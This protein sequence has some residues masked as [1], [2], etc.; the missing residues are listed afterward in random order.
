MLEE[1]KTIDVEELKVLQMDVLDAVAAF[2]AERGIP[3]SLACGTMLG[4]VRHRGYIPW[5]DDIDIYLLRADYDRL[6]REFPQERSHV[7]L[8]ALERTPHWDKPYAK[9][10]DDRTF[11]VERNN[12]RMRIGVNIDLFPLDAVPDDTS[13]WLRYNRRRRFWQ[14]LFQM[15]MT[16]PD[17]RRPLRKNLALLSVQCLLLPVSAH[18]FACL[19]D[20]MAQRYAEQETTY[21]FECAMGLIQ[22]DRFPKSVCDK[23]ADYPF[24]DRVFRGFAEAAAYLSCAYGDFMKLPPVEKRVSHHEFKAGWK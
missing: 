14:T 12:S 3:Y 4:A 5:D 22:K 21:V 7:R 9:A 10:Y 24:E 19:L 18:R 20:R 2:C 6:L 11:F 23:L 8:A 17:R 1:V 15:K 13:A 16:R